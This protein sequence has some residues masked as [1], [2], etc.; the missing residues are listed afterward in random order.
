[1][2]GHVTLVFAV[3]F[4]DGK[5][6]VF[7]SYMVTKNAKRFTLPSYTETRF[8]SLGKLFYVVNELFDV[9]SIEKR[10]WYIPYF[11]KQIIFFFRLQI[12][13]FS[14][15]ESDKFESIS[16]VYQRKISLLFI[17]FGYAESSS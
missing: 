17:R 10:F 1:M 6:T 3:Q 13:L 8:Y 15:A 5:S 16:F 2:L 7:Q 14:F 4:K 9:K 11:Q 12:Y